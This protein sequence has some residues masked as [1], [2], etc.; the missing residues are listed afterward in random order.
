MRP[1]P[2][3]LPTAH[4][5]RRAAGRNVLGLFHFEQCR[6]QLK[7]ELQCGKATR[8]FQNNLR[9]QNVRSKSFPIF[10]RQLIFQLP[11]L[12]LMPVSP[13]RKGGRARGK[14]DPA[15]THPWLCSFPQR[16]YNAWK[17]FPRTNLTLLTRKR[18]T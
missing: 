7:E 1:S 8:S 10:E 17:N 4:V 5:A 15:V 12:T 16:P 14:H 6:H 18:K 3:M 2:V 9:M 11:E 13:E